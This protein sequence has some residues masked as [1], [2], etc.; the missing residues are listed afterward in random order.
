[1]RARLRAFLATLKNHPVWL[2]LTFY[3]PWAF[4]LLDKMYG[5]ALFTWLTK[6]WSGPDM[7]ADVAFAIGHNLLLVNVSLFLAWMSF[8]FYRMW[9][10]SRPFSTSGAAPSLTASSP[11]AMYPVRPID[12]GSH[13][14]VVG[15]GPLRWP[16]DPDIS[17]NMP[18]L[19]S[20]NAN[21]IIIRGQNRGSQEVHLEDAYLVSGVTGIKAQMEVSL[22]R[23]IVNGGWGEELIP[24]TLINAIPPGAEIELVLNLSKENP[25]GISEREFMRRWGRM[26]FVAKYGGTEYRKVYDERIVAKVFQK[27]R[28]GPPTPRVTK[29]GQDDLYGC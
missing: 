14:D 18:D 4:W 26:S 22:R 1:M 19:S 25:R 20:Y 16:D 17:S 12:G 5:D 21:A 3:W 15:E 2:L 8:L 6:E 10:E 27:I 9:N 23:R 28:Y 13:A 7:L 29:I 24:I 11:P